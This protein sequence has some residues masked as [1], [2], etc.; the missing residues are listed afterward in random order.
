MIAKKID[1]TSVTQ[2]TPPPQPPRPKTIATTISHT[3]PTSK[4]RNMKPLQL[5][6]TAA[7]H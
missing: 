4:H 1:S 6:V 7:E 3:N 2:Q 5:T